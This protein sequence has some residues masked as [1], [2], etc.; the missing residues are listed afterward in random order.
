MNKNVMW[1]CF[2][3]KAAFTLIELLVVVLIIGI[4]AAVAVPQYK[5]A[6]AKSRAVELLSVIK[7]IAQA[8]EVYY[9]ANG[10]YA[11]SIDELDVDM[12]GGGEKGENPGTG[13]EA[14]TYSNG[15]MYR[16]LSDDSSVGTNRTTLCNNFEVPLIHGAVFPDLS[17]RCYAHKSPCDEAWG[18]KICKAM[19]G[20]PDPNYGN[21]YIL[22]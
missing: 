6:V 8:Q 20:T 9:L 1:A 5:I 19:G 4:L 16:V 12:P 7:T 22:P 11:T 14:Y 21:F 2:Y 13:H 17:I 15:N 10:E 3:S 18:H